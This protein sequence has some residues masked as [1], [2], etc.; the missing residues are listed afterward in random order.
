MPC[1]FF[2]IPRNHPA[3]LV[4]LDC[5]KLELLSVNCRTIDASQ[6]RQINEQPNQDK[7]HINKNQSTH[8]TE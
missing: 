1:S 7:S 6:K 8:C 4:M 5:E 3:I 2:V